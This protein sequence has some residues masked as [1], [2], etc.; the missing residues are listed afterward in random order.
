M[1]DD[2]FFVPVP[3]AVRLAPFAVDK[4]P[5]SWTDAVACH[6]GDQDYLI[7]NAFY[8]HLVEEGTAA[9]LVYR[10]FVITGVRA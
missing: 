10:T 4:L 8:A 1:N 9:P 3:L 7:P 5:A 6:I 2:V